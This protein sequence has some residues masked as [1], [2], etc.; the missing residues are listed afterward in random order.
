[1]GEGI[2]PVIVVTDRVDSSEALAD[3]RANAIPDGRATKLCKL[4]GEYEVDGECH[5]HQLP[6][7]TG[8]SLIGFAVAGL[9]GKRLGNHA[10]RFSPSGIVHIVSR[11]APGR[12]MLLFQQVE[13]PRTQVECSVV[14]LK[15]L[16]LEL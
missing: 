6:A 2:L 10:H 11:E 3:S 13:K 4:P 5:R 8:V 9:F 7:S 1:G 12:V 14:L 16:M 15:L